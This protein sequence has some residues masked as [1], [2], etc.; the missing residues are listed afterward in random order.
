MKYIKVILFTIT[1]LFSIKSNAELIDG[2][3][4]NLTDSGAVVISGGDYSGEIVIP[5]K[6]VSS[7]R[8]Y[9]V[10]A[11]G[12]QAFRKCYS[13][14]SIQ[15]PNTVKYIYSEAF[16]FD[17]KLN[18]V[19][20]SINLRSIA[21]QAFKECTSLESISLPNSITDIDNGVFEKCTN[22]KE[23]KL[24]SS[25]KTIPVVCFFNCSSLT[26]IEIPNSITDIDNSAFE[27]CINLKTITIPNNVESLGSNVFYGCSSLTNLSIPNSVT[28]IGPRVFENCTS[29]KGVIIPNNV[30]E[31]EYET[32]RGCSNLTSIVI[33]DGIT[34]IGFNAFCGC[35]LT[36]ITIPK[37]VK[38][39]GYGAFCCESLNTIIVAS[40][41]PYYNSQN[42]CNAIIE[43]STNTLVAGCKNSSIPY[44]V[45]NIWKY[46]FSN[47]TELASISIP[48]SVTSIGEYTF[49]GCSALS[50]VN[51]T[52]SVTSIGTF[53]FSGCTSLKKI[54]LPESLTSIGKKSFDG[55]TQLKNVYIKATNPPILSHREFSESCLITIPYGCYASYS[56]A[57]YWKEMNLNEE[58]T[59]DNQADGYGYIDLGLPSGRLW[60]TSNLGANTPEEYGY[61]YAWGEV[62]P[63][64]IYTEEN[65]KWGWLW[66]LK[67]YKTDDENYSDCDLK[68]ELDLEDDAAYVNIGERWRIPSIS[69]WLELKSFCTWEKYSIK[70]VSGYKVTGKNGMSIFLPAAGCKRE[71]IESIGSVGWYQSRDLC[72]AD[73]DE[74]RAIYFNTSRS[75]V[76]LLHGDEACMWRKDG[77]TIRPIYNKEIRAITPQNPIT[78]EA[79]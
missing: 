79:R 37:S 33:P 28:K 47:C 32:F 41:N 74:A 43:T 58:F 15:M 30:T 56:Q 53:A 42:N 11:I 21:R 54:V 9:T 14:T 65:Y 63:K 8:Q 73:N 25:L 46:A 61:Y 45:K 60:A 68:N 36:S 55:C 78:I 38:N 29:L 1:I 62:Y 13:L 5:E 49:Y 66:T 20:L 48:N 17:S 44:S 64:K 10:I 51:M 70:G 22:L 12:A 24:S 67:K 27:G 59:A 7:G 72:K 52:N 40:E 57:A 6:I 39:I 75:S 34:S 2:I 31:I 26:S 71:T 77:L 3:C 4:Y 69:D 19:Q 23:V 18:H 50:S 35:K 16:E 76:I